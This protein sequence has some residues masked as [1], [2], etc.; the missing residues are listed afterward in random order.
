MYSIVT[1]YVSA[2]P[3]SIHVV[4]WYY[5]VILDPYKLIWIV[6]LNDMMGFQ[7]NFKQSFRSVVVLAHAHVQ[8]YH[9]PCLM[10]V[11]TVG[12]FLI[13]VYCG[14]LMAFVFNE[15]EETKLPIEVFMNFL[16]AFSTVLMLIFPTLSFLVELHR[17]VL[18]WGRDGVCSPQV[19]SNYTSTTLIYWS[20]VACESSKLLYVVVVT[21]IISFGTTHCVQ[22]K[23]A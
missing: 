18:K 13:L 17:G 12:V 1:G 10:R 19:G 16:Q 4:V 15:K 5:V 2:Q 22:G 23:V 21:D 9:L 14:S 7:K 6:F 20:N 3:R 11:D 8:A